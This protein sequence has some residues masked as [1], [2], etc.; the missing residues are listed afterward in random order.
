[1]KMLKNRTA[2][3]VLCI[4]LSLSICFIL[5]PLFNAKTNEEVEIVMVTKNISKGEVITKDDVTDLVVG[6]HNLPSSV[7][8]D[9]NS[10]IGKYATADLMVGDYVLK[11][12]V[13]DTEYK[14]NSYLYDLDGSKQ[15]MSISI[16]SF[17]AGLSAKLMAGDIISIIAPDYPQSGNASIPPELQYVKVLAVTG[18]TGI[19]TDKQQTQTSST[20]STQPQLPATITLLVSPAQSKLLAELEVNGKSYIVLVYRGNKENADKFL[21]AQEDVLNGK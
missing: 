7:L 16:K 5:T 2:L 9:P 19:D 11:D 20:S 4:V 18:S 13:T 10:V 21:Q 12:D 3:G 14:D 8:R 17:A 6:S 1:M 15:A